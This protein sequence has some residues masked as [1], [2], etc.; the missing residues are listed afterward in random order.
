[1]SRYTQKEISAN[2]IKKSLDTRKPLRHSY[3][4]THTGACRKREKQEPLTT[5]QHN[6]LAAIRD[7]IRTKKLSPTY[8]EVAA[9]LGV[10]KGTAR[11]AINRLQ[12]KKMLERGAG[13][14]RSLIV[15]RLGRIAAN[16]PQEAV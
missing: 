4:V 9:C 14:Y 5:A 12:R 7:H 2:I 3:G 15:T 11:Q 16:R 6:T 8:E 10:S 13:R 1:M